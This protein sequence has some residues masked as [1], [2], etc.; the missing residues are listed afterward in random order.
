MGREVIQHARQS[1]SINIRSIQYE[2]VLKGQGIDKKRQ[3]WRGYFEAWKQMGNTLP[4][5]YE[6]V[7]MH[8][9][10]MVDLH[11]Y[12][13]ELKY[14][15]DLDNFSS[16][17]EL[18]GHVENKLKKKQLIRGILYPL[19][20]P[21]S[22]ARK[23]SNMAY[24]GET[25]SNKEKPMLIEIR[26]A[27]FVNKGAELM[28]RSIVAKL[29]EELPQA[30]LVMAPPLVYDSYPERGALGLYQKLWLRRYRI[31]WGHL[32]KIIPAKLRQMYGMVLDSDLDVVLDASGFSY[33]DQWGE[34][35][36]IEAASSIKNW[37][38]KGTKVVF[39]PQAFGPFNGTK[40]RQAFKKVAESADL[41]FPR[42]EVS[43]RHVTDL[44][45]EREHIKMA[46]DFTN[47][48]SGDVPRDFDAQANRFCII[49]NYRMVDKTSKETYSNYIPFLITCAKY[50]QEQG[51]MPFFL[52]HEGEKDLWLGQQV[53]KGLDQDINIVRETHALRIKGII[54]AS[55][56]VISSRFHGLV[57]ALSQGIPALATGWSHKY[58]M[59]FQDYGFPEG[60]LAVDSAP[61]EIRGRIDLISQNA[62]RQGII[63]S[64][65]DSSRV[66]KQAASMM[67][68]EVLGLLKNCHV[69]G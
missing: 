59:L 8:A 41:M 66:Q 9:P 25:G 69:T 31:Q 60:M 7:K 32:G 64:L 67:W 23:V 47:L 42:D 1:N 20:L 24:R 57:S 13:Q 22:V 44:V 16:R 61:E 17:K 10:L 43:Y 50:L 6:Q 33:S 21:R 35:S 52:I 62:S 65:L 55:D 56:G 34:G 49:P 3:Q 53:A 4:D 26:K 40:A 29:R 68:E 58:E 14:S 39:M 30:R 63:K 5:Y 18:I 51:A 48:V 28:L 15:L 27:A 38:K 2:Q 11:K 36:S 12:Q 54:G 46:P 37:K 45:G 19:R